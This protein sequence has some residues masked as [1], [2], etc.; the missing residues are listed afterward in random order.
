MVPFRLQEC[1]CSKLSLVEPGQ[2]QLAGRVGVGGMLSSKLT[3]GPYHSKEGGTQAEINPLLKYPYGLD[4]WERIPPPLPT[5]L[6]PVYLLI[7][8]VNING[9]L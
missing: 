4:G 3:G 9:Y 1:F 8:P 6:F 2:K 7:A 5:I